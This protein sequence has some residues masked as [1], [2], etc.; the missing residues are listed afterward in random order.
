MP[1]HRSG[2][3]ARPVQAFMLAWS[4]SALVA[5]SGCSGTQK[6]GGDSYLSEYNSRNYSEAYRLAEEQAARSSG[7]KKDQAALIAGLSA[8][9]MN[10]NDDAKRWLEPLAVTSK[11]EQIAG[12]AG[13]TLG[14]LAAES[15][16]H[17]KAVRYLSEA[18]EKLDG[19][20]AARAWLYA[21]D[22]YR[23]LNKP[24][25]AREAYA[26]AEGLVTD[27]SDLEAMARQRIAA[28]IVP[29]FTGEPY[30]GV[31]GTSAPTS[32]PFTLQMGAFSSQA[33]AESA[34]RRLGRPAMAIG[35]PYVVQTT[36]KNG[37]PMWA[38]RVGGFST[39]DQ[40]R[41]AAKA[42]QLQGAIPV[43]AR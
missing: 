9:A 32:A 18:G 10:R 13:A 2:R 26:K 27:G 5:L 25:E 19:N 3:V 31:I 14:I 28:P 21:G 30:R 22:S 20:D 38:L 8:H 29:Q 34:A 17:D 1:V 39:A 15:R 37:K 23:A 36:A 11:D 16:Q 33:N 35:Q 4:V 40:A 24:S 42:A 12:R 7:A 6:A 43:P 41:Q